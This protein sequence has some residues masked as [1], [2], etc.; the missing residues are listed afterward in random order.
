MKPNIY[1]ALDFVG[2]RCTQPNLRAD[3]NK[4]LGIA[5]EYRWSNSVTVKI[6]PRTGKA[7]TAYPNMD[8]GYKQDNEMLKFLKN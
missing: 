1:S 4:I 7:Y 2:F 3:K 5:G 8:N 6:D